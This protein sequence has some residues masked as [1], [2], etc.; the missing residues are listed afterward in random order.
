MRSSRRHGWVFGLSISL[1][2]G[3]MAGCGQR[4]AVQSCGQQGSDACDQIHEVRMRDGAILSTSVHPLRDSSRSVQAVPPPNFIPLRLDTL[5]PSIQNTFAGSKE[6]TTILVTLRDDLVMPVFPELRIDQLRDSPA[7]QRALAR[8]DSLVVRIKN[9]RVREFKE[10]FDSLR[11]LDV[12]VLESFWLIN[13]M[14]VSV[15]KENLAKIYA[16]DGVDFVDPQFQS[17]RPP[18]GRSMDTLIASINHQLRES[19]RP[20]AAPVSAGRRA[21]SSDPYFDFTD[22][23]RGWIGLLD[24]GVLFS[25]FQFNSP[26]VIGREGDCVNGG[27]ECMTRTTD[28]NPYEACGDF[29]HGTSSA[30]IMVANTN[31]GDSLR[32]VTR[33]TLDSYRVY[34]CDSA[35][36][37]ETHPVVVLDYAAVVRGFQAAVASLDKVIVAE[38]QGVSTKPVK[39]DGRWTVEYESYLHG[40]L[41]RAANNAFDA[42]AAVVGSV[43]DSWEFV[44]QPGIANKVI[45]VG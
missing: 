30:A 25:H 31:Q 4:P 14:L 40:I 44:T 7:N 32:G 22:L 2:V 38:I 45:G 35:I 26:T 9:A 1:C 5:G 15:P 28:F 10:T 39:K 24:T 43:G 42:G 3:S 18:R 8:A 23:G 34:A 13:T 41:S 36:P 6:D 20:D 33:A 21:I 37:P 12:E 19:S 16:I 17:D 11:T 29:P 27:A